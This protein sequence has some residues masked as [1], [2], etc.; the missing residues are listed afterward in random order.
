MLIQEQGAIRIK[1]KDLTNWVLHKKLAAFISLLIKTFAH[2]GR[3]L[4]V[5]L[6][7][8]MTP[9][10]FF[11][12]N[13]LTRGN[14]SKRNHDQAMAKPSPSF[15]GDPSLVKVGE[16]IWRSRKDRGLL[17]ELLAVDAGEDRTYMGGIE[18]G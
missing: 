12:F 14:K 11:I 1:L 8:A 13:I 6:C 5:S 2:R 16:V 9:Y 18:R 7:S 4:V 3:K 17:Q 10:D 15:A